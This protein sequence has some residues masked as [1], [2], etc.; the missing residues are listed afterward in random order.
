[1]EKL[2]VGIVGFGGIFN[3]Q[4][5]SAWISSDRAEIV[6]ICDIN[7]DKLDWAKSQ[8]GDK[9]QYFTDYKEMIDMVKPDIVDICTPNYV[10][11]PISCYALDHGAHALCEKPDAINV[12]DAIKM[13][14]AQ[15]R[16]GKVLMVVRNNRHVGSSQ[17]LKNMIANGEF[18]DIYT[19][20]CGWIRKRGIPGKGG[21]FT[22]KAMSGGGPLID[23]GVHMIDLAL[24]MMGNPK[25]VSV[26]G[27]TYCKFANNEEES[28]S[29]HSQFGE[30]VEDGT[31]DVEDLAI[32]FIKFE[33]GASLQL[34]FS[35]ASNIE[36]ETAFVELRGTEK[37]VKWEGGFF[38]LYDGKQNDENEDR[39]LL[40]KQQQYYGDRPIG[41]GGNIEHFLDVILNGAK[42]DYVID[43]GID[44]IKILSGIYESAETGKEV[45]L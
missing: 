3:S 24:Y 36:K 16:S 22:T 45:R 21:W 2:K 7:P 15:E 37:G 29:V 38:T 17:L 9:V 40:E 8:F 12:E 13:K 35:W 28:D 23:L 1:M 14:E 34:E 32:G 4:H 43:Q 26:V 31:F 20:R 18:G 33:N 19:G 10:H 44:M 25:P 27:S 6:A 42:P 11:S 41:H 39:L 5:K 30:K